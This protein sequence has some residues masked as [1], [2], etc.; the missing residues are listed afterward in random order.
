MQ[1]I[2]VLAWLRGLSKE[3]TEC[4]EGCG[5]VYTGWG[6]FVGAVCGMNKAIMA[7]T[8]GAVQTRAASAR[9]AAPCNLWMLLGTAP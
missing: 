4:R 2:Q 9:H 7:V 6:F 3:K 1:S 5:P 8:S